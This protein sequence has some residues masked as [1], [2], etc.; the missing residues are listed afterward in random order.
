VLVEI[1]A[2]TRKVYVPAAIALFVK[3]ADSICVGAKDEVKV[4]YSTP[5][6]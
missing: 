2:V 5:P 1:L 3:A 6:I 4:K